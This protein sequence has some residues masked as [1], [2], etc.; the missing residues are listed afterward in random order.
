MDYKRDKDQVFVALS[1]GDHIISNLEK[2]VL[3]ENILS[4]HI[5]AIGAV[6]SVE[7]GYLEVSEKS[8]KRKIFNCEYEIINISG[9][10]TLKNGKPFIHAHIVLSDSDYRVFGGHL[11]EGYISS[12][13]ELIINI[14]KV[15][16]DRKWDEN[17]G[18]YT[19]N[20]GH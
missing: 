7:I 15:T 4:G 12:V 10:I 9:N 17:I 1:S 3:K 16:I 11:F 2:I 5:F 13:G 18:L 20:I 6:S 19:W 14:G 8:Y